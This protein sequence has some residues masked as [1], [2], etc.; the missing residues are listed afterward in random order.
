MSAPE[1]PDDIELTVT[2]NCKPGRFVAVASYG[3]LTPHRDVIDL[4]SDL[5]RKRFINR[6]LGA[7]FPTGANGQTDQFRQSLN[8]RLLRFAACPP[9]APEVAASGAEALVADPRTEALAGMP[10]DALAEADV[11]LADPNLLKRVVTDI[12]AVGVVGERRLAATLYLVGSSVQLPK[13]L[14]AI[15]RGSSSSGKSYIVETVA[16]LFPPEVVLRATSL[17]T[18]AL[19]YFP[20]GTLRHR[21]IVAGERSRLEDDDRAEATRALREMIESGRLSKAV[22]VKEH[23][24]MTTQVIEQEGPIAYVETTS[25]GQLFDEDANRCLLLATDEQEAQTRRILTATAA[26]ATG[27]DRPDLER[28]RAIHYAVQRMLPRCAVVIPFADEVGALYPTERLDARRSFRHLL[29]L[30]SASALLHFRQRE[31]A[32]GGAIVATVNDYA[33]AE[34]L[35]RGPFG[36]AA[37]GVSDGAREFLAALRSRFGEEGFSTTEAQTV[38]PGAR[39][40]RYSRLRELN[41]AGAVEQTEAPRGAVPARWRLTGN[42]PSDGSGALP[43]VSAVSERLSGCTNAHAT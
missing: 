23:D 21:F 39:R 36:A 12:E 32:T 41:A 14:A 17:T 1:Q 6:A 18:N 4:N 22:P 7:L 5:S 15:V 40:V 10:P 3:S 38:G 37:S 35:A 9:G 13:P 16:S 33:V 28:V 19:Y 11:L 27:R 24:R 20:P 8:E 42:D 34:R 30:V 26:A 29:N 25:L 2:P 31:R 43:S